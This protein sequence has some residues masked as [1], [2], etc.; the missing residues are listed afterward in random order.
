MQNCHAKC[1]Y[2]PI[3]YNIANLKCV[4]SIVATTKILSTLTTHWIFFNV[5]NVTKSIIEKKMQSNFSLPY[6]KC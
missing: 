4:S 1:L 6:E 5:T 3:Q 2:F